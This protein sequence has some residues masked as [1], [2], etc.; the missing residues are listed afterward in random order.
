M[1]DFDVGDIVIFHCPE[2]V[3]KYI[4][5]KKEDVEECKSLDGCKM[6]IEKILNIGGKTCYRLDKL[7]RTV[8]T[9]ENIKLAPLESISNEDFE[10]LLQ[11]V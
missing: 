1:R 3:Y 9:A 2:E 8:T 10:N 11:E 6:E 4:G 7:K 5:M